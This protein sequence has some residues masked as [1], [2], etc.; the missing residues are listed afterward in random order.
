MARSILA[1][2]V[3]LAAGL[4]SADNSV[5]V[6]VGQTTTV[7]VG[8]AKGLNCDD[9]AVAQVEIRTRSADNNELVITGLKPGKT[10]CRAGAP[11]A[12]ATALVHI[13]V[14]EKKD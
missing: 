12:G 9:L 5:T 2:A 7:D 13:H 8:L 11:G 14:V 10:W 6:D 3:L 1:L 4:A